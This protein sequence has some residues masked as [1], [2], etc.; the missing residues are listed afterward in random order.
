MHST[1][2]CRGKSVSWTRESGVGLLLAI[3][4][5]SVLSIMTYVF[6]V[7]VDNSVTG[8][9]VES[10]KKNRDYA[11]KALLRAAQHPDALWLSSRE[12]E[13]GELLKCINAVLL[14]QCGSTNKEDPKSFKLVMPLSREDALRKLVMTTIDPNDAQGGF[15]RFGNDN[16]PVNSKCLFRGVT[17]FWLECPGGVNC[18]KQGRIRIRVIVEKNSGWVSGPG[19]G[20]MQKMLGGLGFNPKS[21]K[22][23]GEDVSV[24]VMSIRGVA[25]EACPPGAY[26]T[27]VDKAGVVQCRCWLKPTVDSNGCEPVT[28]PDGKQLMGIDLNPSFT[29]DSSLKGSQFVLNCQDP[30]GQTCDKATSNRDTNTA[31]CPP[32]WKMK[33]FAPPRCV[34]K[35]PST[36]GELDQIIEDNK[37]EVSRKCKKYKK[38]EVIVGYKDNGKPIIKKVETSECEKWDIKY[39]KCGR[40]QADCWSKF[41]P[42]KCTDSEAYCCREFG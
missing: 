39:D 24:P 6:G 33:G 16:C 4:V 11:Y 38:E 1:D 7:F 8:R 26:S 20:L 32:K 9:L 21:S 17:K 22:D 42:A 19:E 41:I 37:W 10:T 2:K 29:P 35:Y 25:L 40:R 34:L 18:D 15:D 13:N 36:L 31:Q 28:C 5:V 12:P 27:G 30:P 3:S 14:T 23:E